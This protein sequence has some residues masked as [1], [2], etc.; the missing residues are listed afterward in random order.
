MKVRGQLQAPADLPQRKNPFA[1]WSGGW[2]ERFLE[3]KNLFPIGIQTPNRPARSSV[4]T[5]LAN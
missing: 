5:I 1:H 3:L 4:I 2:Y